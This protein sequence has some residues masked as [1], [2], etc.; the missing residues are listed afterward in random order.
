MELDSICIELRPF[1]LGH[2]RQF[3]C[4]V[5]YGVCVINFSHNFQWFF[6]KSCIIVVNIMKMCM[7]VFNGVRIVTTLFELSHFRQCSAL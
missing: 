5:E 6:L 2:F 1:E 4:I 3:V 7:W